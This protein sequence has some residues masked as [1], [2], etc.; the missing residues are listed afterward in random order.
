M[1]MLLLCVNWCGWGRGGDSCR[2]LVLFLPSLRV[3]IVGSGAHSIFAGL[4][5]FEME[6]LT[7]KWGPNSLCCAG[8]SFSLKDSTWISSN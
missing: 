4:A 6:V 8:E 3:G 2:C 7:R 5:S 1:M